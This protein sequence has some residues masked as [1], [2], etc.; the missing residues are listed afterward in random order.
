[1]LP[2]SLNMKKSE[3]TIIS[4]S[5]IRVKK[6]KPN[7]SSRRKAIS[8]ASRCGDKKH[9]KTSQKRTE[10]KSKLRQAIHIILFAFTYIYISYP[11]IAKCAMKHG[12]H[13]SSVIA[14]REKQ[15]ISNFGV[16]PSVFPL[17]IFV[18]TPQL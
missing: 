12:K 2:F 15:N 10:M 9:M 16:P 14:K 11:H 18:Y 8:G 1:M 5:V 13:L 6:K 7:Q 17:L 4:N 3:M